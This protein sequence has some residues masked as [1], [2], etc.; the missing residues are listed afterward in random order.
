[1]RLFKKPTTLAAC[2]L[3]IITVAAFA[4]AGSMATSAYAGS[5]RAA[6]EKK[7]ARAYHKRYASDKVIKVAITQSDWQAV[8]EIVKGNEVTNYYIAAQVAVDKG[9]LANVWQIT[10]RKAGSKVELS[11]VG[12]NFKIR[13]VDIK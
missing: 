11:S 10:L 3:F 8:K 9:E 13:K 6:L 12:S 7:I 2:S 5:D 1:M 4:Q